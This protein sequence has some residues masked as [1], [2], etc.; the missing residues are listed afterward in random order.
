MA[1]DLDWPYNK[2]HLAQQRISDSLQLTVMVAL[3][4]RRLCMC[5]N[6]NYDR[7]Y[8]NTSSFL[9]GLYLRV[10]QYIDYNHGNID[11][12]AMTL[13]QQG[14]INLIFMANKIFY[15]HKVV[16]CTKD[17]GQNKISKEK[18]HNVHTRLSQA[19]QFREIHH[20]MATRLS[21]A[22]QNWREI[23]QCSYKVVT[24]LSQVN[25]N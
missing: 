3:W 10:W 25:Q 9:F 23:S 5:R 16:T 8:S 20:N 24:R 2:K 18:Y 1:A 19:K 15:R 21:Q 17:L 6:N 12:F 11:R 4:Q 14:W 7:C 22:K 13:Y